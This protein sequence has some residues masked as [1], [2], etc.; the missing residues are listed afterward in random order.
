M[1]FKNTGEPQEA[2]CFIM[3]EL[4]LGLVNL[5]KAL[6]ATKGIIATMEQILIAIDVAR[7]E[8]TT[9]ILHT[10]KKKVSSPNVSKLDTMLI[11]MLV[12]T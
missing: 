9:P 4:N 7:A 5:S 1:L 6:F 8:P 12:F 10:S 2:I 3:P 11:I